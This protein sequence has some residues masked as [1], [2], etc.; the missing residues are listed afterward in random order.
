MRSG[1]LDIGQ[2]ICFVFIDRDEATG[3]A[4]GRNMLHPTMLQVVGQQCC[5][6]LHQA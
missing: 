3:C 2:V 1:W 4:N 6:R 5:I